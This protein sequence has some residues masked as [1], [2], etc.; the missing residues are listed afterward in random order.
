MKKILLCFHGF[1]VLPVGFL[2]QEKNKLINDELLVSEKIYG[3][4]LRSLYIMATFELKICLGLLWP[5]TRFQG[6][7]EEEK[8]KADDTTNSNPR[9][10]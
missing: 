4:N 3:I 8:Q 9:T 5:Q 6:K 10:I 1:E 7:T 2:T